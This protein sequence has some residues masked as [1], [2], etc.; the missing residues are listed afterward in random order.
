MPTRR[1]WLPG[2]LGVRGIGPWS[3]AYVALRALGDPDAFA[4]GDLG[5]RRAVE[6]LGRPGTPA[7]V[8]E[9][10][11]KWRPWRAYAMVHLWAFDSRVD[12][13]RGTT[14]EAA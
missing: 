12:A 4:P 13:P 10:A 1:W 2:L 8:L 6:R 3:V 5:V 9:L 14:E 7:A 11:S